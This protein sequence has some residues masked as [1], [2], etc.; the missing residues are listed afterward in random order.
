MRRRA[1]SVLVLAVAV[2]SILVS[3]F[4][5]AVIARLPLLASLRSE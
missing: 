5:V 3:W 4:A 1:P 2:T